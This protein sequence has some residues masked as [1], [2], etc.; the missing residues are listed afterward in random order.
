MGLLKL[1]NEALSEYATDN[2]VTLYHY[3]DVDEEELTLSPDEFGKNPFTRSDKKATD[4]P[5]V[6]FYLDLDDTERFFKGQSS[7]LYSTKVP[8]DD[9]Y[10]VLTDPLDIKQEIRDENNGALN[11]D[12]LLRTIHGK[13]YNG[14]YYSS[15][16]EVVIWFDPITVTKHTEEEPVVHNEIP[17]LTSSDIIEI[18]DTKEVVTISAER[19][20]RTD[21]QNRQKTEHLKNDLKQLP[22]KFTKA[23]GGFVETVETESGETE[24]VDVEE[25]SF[26]VWTNPEKAEEFKSDMLD[27][28]KK[29]G[30]EAIMVKHHDED[31][32]YF[33]GGSGIEREYVGSFKPNTKG[34][35][36]TRIGN[37]YFEFSDSVEEPQLAE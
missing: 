10:N 1:L 18:F 28:G 29:Y 15:R 6:F 5:R 7:I 34:Q 36:F 20:E 25:E 11:F 30:Q 9:I 3:T 26:M 19:N 17:T 22:Y 12:K 32:A 8:V 24:E 33:T 21:A 14:M 35:Y 23:Y 13:G 4:Y 16:G 27:L 31:Q 37:F 2:M